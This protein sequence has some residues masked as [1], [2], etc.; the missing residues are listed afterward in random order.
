MRGQEG[1]RLRKISKKVIKRRDNS[2]ARRDA[3]AEDRSCYCGTSGPTDGVRECEES[4]QPSSTNS[5]RLLVRLMKELQPC[6]YVEDLSGNV[7]VKADRARLITNV[8]S[9]L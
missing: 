3:L 2:E 1:T 6:I 5:K 8:L 7:R 9:E 4:Y